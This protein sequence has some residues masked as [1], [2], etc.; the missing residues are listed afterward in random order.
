MHCD[1]GSP[2]RQATWSIRAAM[3]Y[4]VSCNER[5]S[6]SSSTE[7]RREQWTQQGGVVSVVNLSWRLCVLLC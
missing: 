4:V 3:R 2:T 5:L 6:A 7:C 1:I